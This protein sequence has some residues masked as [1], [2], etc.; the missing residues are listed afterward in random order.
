MS[1]TEQN[2]RGRR[3]ERD[4]PGVEGAGWVG[5]ATWTDLRSPETSEMKEA[6]LS[7]LRDSLG[8]THGT[9]NVFKKSEDLGYS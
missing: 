1:P 2:A 5:K 6:I 4:H 8:S 3:T 7:D 9:S